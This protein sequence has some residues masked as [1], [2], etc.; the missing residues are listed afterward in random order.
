MAIVVN[1]KQNGKTVIVIVANNIEITSGPAQE[2]LEWCH[3]MNG[4]L[5]LEEAALFYSFPKS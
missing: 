1:H 4:P 2:P 3:G 5:L